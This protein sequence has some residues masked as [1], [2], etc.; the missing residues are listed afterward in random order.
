MVDLCSQQG[1]KY[2]LVFPMLQITGLRSF[3]I[4]ILREIACIQLRGYWGQGQGLYPDLQDYV[5]F[6]HPSARRKRHETI[7]QS[8]L[9]HGE[10]RNTFSEPLWMPET[11]DST[12][13]YMYCFLSFTHNYEQV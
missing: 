9:I 2:V 10:Y 5:P 1:E 11:V 4:Y 13:P 6:I 3:L 8:P 7:Q 12:E